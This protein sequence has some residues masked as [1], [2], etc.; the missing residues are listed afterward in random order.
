MAKAYDLI[1]IGAGT[2]AMVASHRTASAGWKVAVIDYRP[3]G[4]TCALRGCDPKKM[5]ITGAQ[6]IDDIRRLGE[7]GVVAADA[8]IA[9][10][11]L[12]EFKRTFTG[13]VPDKQQKSYD[14]SGIDTYHAAARFVPDHDRCGREPAGLKPSI[15]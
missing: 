1:V 15:S 3:F 13:A 11:D 12:M 6:V 9:W 7:R 2:A 10:R 14:A 5:L 8:R 4:G